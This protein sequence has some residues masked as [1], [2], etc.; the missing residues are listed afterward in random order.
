MKIDIS[1]KMLKNIKSSFNKFYHGTILG[2]S[3]RFIFNKIPYYLSDKNYI[4][5][6]HWKR[7]GKALNLTNP[8]TLNEKINWLKINDRTPLHT[9]CA[10]KYAVRK[11]VSEKIGDQYL[12]PLYFKTRNPKE[13]VGENIH[14]L[15]CII[16][17]NHDSGGGIFVYN[18]HDYDWLKVQA[19]LTER[20]N[21]NYYNTAR[22]WQYKNIKPCI[23]VEQ[24]LLD[25]DCKVPI[26]YKIHCF[27][28]KPE[29]IQVDF[30][31]FSNHKRN[32]YDISWNLL[33][34]TWSMWENGKPLWNNGKEISRPNN[35]E[36]LLELAGVLSSE[37][38]FAR[39]DFYE[40]GQNIYFGEIT[41]HPGSGFEKIH[42][43][44]WADI[45]GEKLKLPQNT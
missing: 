34:F 2:N 38:I 44:D 15:P 6:R 8:K 43:E 9:L 11:Y 17:T 1:V 39:V 28:G 37:F 16:K 27:N 21:K 7:Y 18:I 23:I 20:L 45:L 3:F 10:D 25:K 24:L 4:K 5:F 40:I 32:L 36:K 31:R 12:I 13:I 14:H 35:L 33:P 41:F 29:I 19:K 22:E 26:D 42:P 30:D